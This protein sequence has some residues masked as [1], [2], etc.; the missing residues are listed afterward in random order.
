MFDLVLLDV[1]QTKYVIK[2]SLGIPED[3]QGWELRAQQLLSPSS[4]WILY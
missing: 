2:K 4:F 1:R 3:P